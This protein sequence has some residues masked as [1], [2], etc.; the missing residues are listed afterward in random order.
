MN[1]VN[2]L[3]GISMK[4]CDLFC[5]ELVIIVCPVK[6]AY[7]PLLPFVPTLVY[8]LHFCL[9]SELE[10]TSAFPWGSKEEVFLEHSTLGFKI[11]E[12][13]IIV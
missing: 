3:H 11:A 10:I 12:V 8:L 7:F 1:T 13:W 2:E 9:G 4:Y 5:C 6:F